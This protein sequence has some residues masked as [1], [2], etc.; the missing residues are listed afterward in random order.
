M[1]PSTITT[2]Q[3][4]AAIIQK[5]VELGIPP[6]H[7]LSSIVVINKKPTCSAELMLAMIYRDH[8]DDAAQV[9]ETTAQRCVISYKRRSWTARLSHAFTMEEARTAGLA[10]SATWQKFPAAMLR[11]RCISAMAR[12]AF[13]DTIGGMYTAE[14]MGATVTI[15]DGQEVVNVTPT[16]A[17]PPIEQPQEVAQPRERT[18]AERKEIGETMAVIKTLAN[19]LGH[20]P[21][22]KVASDIVALGPL[23]DVPETTTQGLTL[24]WLIYLRDTMQAKYAGLCQQEDN[25]MELLPQGPQEDMGKVPF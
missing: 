18:E 22:P 11:A 20:T 19:L 14:E 10:T 13:P 12:L 8:G 17:A 5:G 1:L 15:E 6:M 23:Y 24:D 9:T 2:W 7:A 4:A 25:G 3:A 21:I 16:N